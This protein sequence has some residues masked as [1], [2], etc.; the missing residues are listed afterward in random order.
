MIKPHLSFILVAFGIF[1]MTNAPVAYYPEETEQLCQ[2]AEQNAGEDKYAETHFKCLISQN[3]YLKTVLKETYEKAISAA[4]SQTSKRKL[5]E[6]FK[7]ISQRDPELNQL[8][9][10]LNANPKEEDFIIANSQLEY[11]QGIMIC[12]IAE[13]AVSLL[14]KNFR[15]NKNPQKLMETNFKKALAKTENKEALQTAQKQWLK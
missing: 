15:T 1:G 9:S 13:T 2:I 12:D 6:N 8:I 14:P 4:K 10:D 3:D 5:E 7:R 11:E